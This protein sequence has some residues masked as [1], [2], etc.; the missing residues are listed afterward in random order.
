MHALREGFEPI[1]AD[2]YRRAHYIW[3]LRPAESGDGFVLVRLREERD[4]AVLLS[5]TAQLVQVTVALPQATDTCSDCGHDPCTCAAA[6]PML[7][8]G[9]DTAVV[10]E[11]MQVMARTPDLIGHATDFGNLFQVDQDFGA[12]LHAGLRIP[13]HMI[14]QLEGIQPANQMTDRMYGIPSP[15]YP[16]A[17]Q[18]SGA[19]TRYRF[20]AAN[21]PGFV[22][23]RGPDT[24]FLLPHEVKNYLSP[25]SADK[26]PGPH[27]SRAPAAPE[28][29]GRGRLQ[30]LN[31][32]QPATRSDT[33]TDRPLTNPRYTP[34]YGGAPPVQPVESDADS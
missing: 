30:P 12:L 11:P 21:A 25:Q 9:Q 19:F 29:T 5:P 8:P 24:L 20:D 2:L 6:Q 27:R 31:P 33:R 32:A 14:L 4:P 15:T 13:Q 22:G 16:S 18:D 26:P 1:G 17:G 10:V 7:H 34:L 23:Y 28:P 3:Q